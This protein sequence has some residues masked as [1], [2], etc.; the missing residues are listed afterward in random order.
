MNCPL[1]GH[2]KYD[3]ALP[4]YG[5]NA[6]GVFGKCIHAALEHYNNTGDIAAAIVIFND[7]WANPEKVGAPIDTL[8]W[9]NRMSFGGLKERGLEIL[10]SSHDRMNLQK[11][12]V[13]A[14]EHPFL[15]PF[16]RHE[17]NGI[18]DLVEVRKSGRG[19]NLLRVCDYKS[20]TK[21]PNYGELFLDIQFTIYVYASLQPEFWF[22]VEGN[23]DFPALPNAKWLHEMYF[24]LTRRPI[25]VH[26]WNN[27][28]IDAGPRD[29]EDF[30]RLYRLCDEVERAVTHEVYVPKVGEHC[31]ICDFRDN[32]C[33]V[34]IPTREEV[35]AQDDAWL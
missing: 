22:G 9:P 8:V 7:L 19:K 6:K 2:L 32:G 27:K 13:V 28:E 4:V 3:Q 11:R 15:V 26:L 20:A 24:D 21:Q 14:V 25:W 1:A 12:D 33:P 31:T 29:D 17:L 16:G 10:R 23:P 34:T 5:N 18:V 30:M 35:A